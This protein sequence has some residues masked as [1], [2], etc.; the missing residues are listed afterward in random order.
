MGLHGAKWGTSSAPIPH[1]AVPLGETPGQS[2]VA[3]MTLLPG[4]F[5][6]KAGAQGAHTVVL[7]W[8]PAFAGIFNAIALG[9]T[10]SCLSAR[11]P[12]E[13]IQFDTGTARV[14]DGNGEAYTTVP[15]LVGN[16]KKS[17]RRRRFVAQLIWINAWARQ[18]EHATLGGL[19]THGMNAI[20]DA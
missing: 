9:A 6:A 18:L 19:G 8:V 14:A 7:P 16:Q 13:D 20:Q 17:I 4:V 1:T 3:T 5:P 15:H 2:N 11:M 12:F 10:P